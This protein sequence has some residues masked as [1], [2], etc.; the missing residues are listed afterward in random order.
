MLVTFSMLPHDSVKKQAD[1]VSIKNVWWCDAVRQVQLSK[2]G[3]V[4]ALLSNRTAWLWHTG[5]ACWLC[6]ADSAFAASPF[7]SLL[8]LNPALQGNARRRIATLPFLSNVMAL[9]LSTCLD[10]GHKKQQPQLTCYSSQTLS[11]VASM[12][13]VC[14]DVTSR[15]Q[16][17]TYFTAY[18]AVVIMYNTHQVQ[19]VSGDLGRIQQQASSSGRGLP[20]GTL[21]SSTGSLRTGLGQGRGHLEAN[22]AAALALQS[23]EEYKRWL[24]TYASHLAG[25]SWQLWIHSMLC[26][27]SIYSMCMLEQ[28]S[29]V[30]SL[31]RPQA[32]DHRT[33]QDQS[34]Q[35][36]HA[37]R[38][39]IHG[40]THERGMLARSANYTSC[41]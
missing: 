31:A 13:L 19:T 17:T 25:V 5:L 16:F 2:D 6:L 4:H 28:V 21:L 12:P 38:C 30:A 41:C 7:T 11:I 34:K 10:Y 35:G 37:V 24:S 23:P 29:A 1:S 27:N 26:C 18:A 39:S 36:C 22:M 14:A 20:P 32:S 3:G 15:L 8:P 9:C 33:K 40:L